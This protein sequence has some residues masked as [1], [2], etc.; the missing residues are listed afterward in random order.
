MRLQQLGID[1]LACKHMR[2]QQ[3]GSDTYFDG[4]G[5][6]RWRIGLLCNPS[7]TSSYVVRAIACGWESFHGKLNF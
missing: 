1:I 3:L 4:I 2:M 6:W 5:H 7:K